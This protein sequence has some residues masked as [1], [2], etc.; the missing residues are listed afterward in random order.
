MVRPSQFVSQID[1]LGRIVRPIGIAIRWVGA[2]VVVRPQPV[3]AEVRRRFPGGR[4]AAALPGVAVRS[5][6]LQQ[7]R[8][9]S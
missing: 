3:D 2:V 4:I 6:P 7:E 8:E 9:S 1:H 5:W